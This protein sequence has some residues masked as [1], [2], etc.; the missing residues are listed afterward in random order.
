MTKRGQ[1]PQQVAL[2]L[3]AAAG[4]TAAE[5]VGARALVI[6]GAALEEFGLRAHRTSSDVDLWVDP[7]R[8]TSVHEELAR[9]GWVDRPRWRLSD[10]MTTHSVSLVHPQWPCDID[11][12]QSFPGFLES[13]QRAFDCIWARRV[14]VQRAGITCSVPDRA[15]SAA[16]L[17]LH[18]LRSSPEQHRHVHE[19]RDLVA[20]LAAEGD[21]D[22]GRELAQ[23]AKQTGSAG[24][25]APFL[26]AIGVDVPTYDATDPAYIAWV[27]HVNSHNNVTAVFA[28]RWKVASWR[29][30]PRMLALA[31]WP[32]DD[33]LRLAQPHRTMGPATLMWER[34]KRI[35]RSVR[36][37]PLV[38]SSRRQARR[39]VIDSPYTRGDT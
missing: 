10:A 37:L 35:A 33:E 17:A 28:E 16:I 7:A 12:H 9:R 13:P 22:F 32:S 15:S 25:L 23:V 26:M 39:G 6:K 18:S 24:S 8:F 36:S 29:E 21:P 20:L 11:L 38:M 3:A 1:I 31:L 30:R 4:C 5:S 14:A 19:Y 27:T 34:F 2:A